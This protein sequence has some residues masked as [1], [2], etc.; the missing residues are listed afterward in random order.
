VK[1]EIL[2]NV[3]DGGVPHLGCSCEVCEAAREDADKQRYNSSIMIKDGDKEDSVKYL[4]EPTPDVRFQINGD[5][6]DGVF[7]S[8]GH[9]GH[10]TG[11]LHF[12]EEALD[13]EHLPVYVTDKTR[14]F[15]TSNDPYRL[16]ADRDS[17][18]LMEFNDGD[19]T[20]LQGGEIEAVEAQH[21]RLNT[22][23]LGFMI[24][25]ENKKL[26]Y[27]SDIHE[28]T[29]K[30]LD[31][32]KEADIAIV[33][34]TFWN[35]EE[36]DRY[37]EVPHPVMKQTMHKTEDWDTQVIFTHL[38]HTNPALREDTEERQE[39]EERGFKVAEQGMEIEL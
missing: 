33:D 26:F 36:L 32:V 25:G 21:N 16:L 28:W 1:V 15:I 30:T 18:S 38:N 5:Y 7:V 9:L 27:L 13:A 8:H 23:T 12:G 10:I 22:D 2:G 37:E 19:T 4:V 6:L 17:I 34:G 3:Q 29:D 20:G 31:K 24:H 11:L 35:E 39:L 14:D